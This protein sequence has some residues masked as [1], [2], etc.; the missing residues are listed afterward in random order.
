MT[1]QQKKYYL[2]HNGLLCPHCH[3]PVI[4]CNDAPNWETT[5]VSRDVT[6]VSCEKSWVD[7]YTL[8]SVAEIDR[9]GA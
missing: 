6:C 2:E 9:D 7:I 1:E 5:E 8:T 3:S 4:E